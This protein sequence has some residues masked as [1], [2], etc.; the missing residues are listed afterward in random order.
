MV[1]LYSAY[2]SVV[3]LVSHCDIILRANVFLPFA[4]NVASLLL[5][6]LF[7]VDHMFAAAVYVLVVTAASVLFLVC[8]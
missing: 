3:H 5:L 6:V 4:G 2:R 1:L 8:S 7:S